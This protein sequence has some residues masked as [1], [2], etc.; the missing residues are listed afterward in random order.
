LK[1]RTVVV[2]ES[3]AGRELATAIERRGAV[4][5]WAPALAEEPD[6]DPVA[7]AQLI[8]DCEREAPALVVF[9]TGVGTTA[10][11]RATDGLGLTARWQA[12]LGACQIAVRGPKPVAELRR[13]DVRIDARAASPFTTI[14]LLEAIRGVPIGGR[15][16]LVQRY[17][18]TNVE[19]VRG[20]EARDARPV[21]IASYR[22]ALPA[23][24]APLLLAISEIQSGAVDAAVFTS[25]AQAH[26]LVRVAR[27]ANVAGPLIVA[28]NL[29]T[30][31]SIGPVCSTALRSV[32]I[33]VTV[34]ADPPKLG[35]L[36]ASLDGAL[37]P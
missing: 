27:E 20:L 23:D 14:Q 37:Q 5:I 17:G 32:G 33:T 34:E 12:I 6:V 26:N 2:F 28:L 31:V 10:L 21:E 1:G 19:L 7:I 30:V 29:M 15:R 24:R 13:R 11:F 9:Q 25:A 16:V 3:R 36:V 8:D 35:A 22:W 4:T 18:A